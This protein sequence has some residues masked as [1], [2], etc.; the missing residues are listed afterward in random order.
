MKN[1]ATKSSSRAAA[2]D[3]PAH[4]DDGARKAIAEQVRAVL[5][6]AIDLQ[7][8]VKVAHWNV[9]GPQF[10]ALHPLFDTFAQTLTGF[11]DELAERVL[12]LGHL[13]IGTAR[14]VAAHSRLP[15]YPQDVTIDLEH[16]AL[17]HARCQAFLPGAHAARTV[18]DD[19]GD[20]DTADL[21]TEIVSEVDKQ[22]WFLRATLGR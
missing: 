14:H 11:V 9:K 4:L 10:A 2:G 5:A 22:A 8:Q 15:D 21:L 12:V 13:A 18:A 7:S 6:D 1:K 16:V 17:L 19:A 3:G 20:V